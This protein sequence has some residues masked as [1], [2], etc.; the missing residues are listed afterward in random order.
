MTGESGAKYC[1][2]CRK[3]VHDLRSLSEGEALAYVRSQKGALCVRLLVVT[4]AVAA[5]VASPSPPAVAPSPLSSIVEPT[6]V[7]STDSD[8]DGIPDVSDACPQEPGAPSTNPAANGCPKL[9]V[10]ESVG[11]LV[12]LE[13][14]HFARGDRTVVQESF[15]IIDETIKALQANPQL[16]R[17]AVEGHASS[18]EPGAQALSETRAKAVLARITAAGID[19]QRLVVRGYGSTR[20]ID[21]NKT[22]D[23]RAHNRRVEFRVLADGDSTAASNVSCAPGASPSSRPG[24]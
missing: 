18:D 22:S 11:E 23:G 9:V 10:V 15:P 8:H 20:P 24:P 6:H 3:H 14:V 12:I 17:V 4:T 2:S 1:D 19:P 21:D 13:Q 16:P 7:A 5:C